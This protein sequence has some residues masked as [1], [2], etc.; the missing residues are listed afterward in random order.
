MDRP[1][2]YPGVRATPAGKIEINYKVRGR[3]YWETL[4]LS[5]TARNLAAAAKIREEHKARAKA[6]LAPIADPEVAYVGEVAQSYLDSI[7]LRLKPSTVQSYKEILNI[8]WLPALGP[9]PIREIRFAHLREIDDG[10]NWPSPKTRKNAL[11]PLYGLF[12]HALSGD[13]I[14]ANPVEKFPYV[15]LER[16]QPQAYTREQRAE[17]LK[18]I[19][20]NA[21]ASP[22]M[23]FRTAF[24][25]GM[26]TGELLAL[27]W[28]R[29]DGEG[30]LVSEATVRH[31]ITS[32]K[33]RAERYVPLTTALN[34]ELREFPSR[35]QKG[36]VFLNQYG[37]AYVRGDKLNVWL[38][39]AIR[40]TEVPDLGGRHNPYPWRH[41]FI[42][43]ALEEGVDPVLLA[44]TTGHSV[45]TMLK[46][47]RQVRKRADYGDHINKIGDL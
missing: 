12:R 28:S 29:Y 26:R 42:T 5:P 1:T 10:L 21:P 11:V 24:G 4:D 19:K 2:R 45:E 32:T 22:Y 20:E 18:W 36:Y 13:L 35:W 39:K 9:L 47:Y 37:R 46:V 41:T 40:A 15:K 23:Y 8:Y 14:D 25:T 17:L 3:H 7:R 6:G 33:T 43:L 34:G 44:D 16:K 31:E 38:R 27:H 30:F